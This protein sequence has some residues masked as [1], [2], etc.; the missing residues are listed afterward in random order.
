MPRVVYKLGMIKSYPKEIKM[1]LR[2]KELAESEGK[3]AAI[4]GIL[5]RLLQ[6]FSETEDWYD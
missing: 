4:V 3:K 1:L 6:L 5:R 2:Q